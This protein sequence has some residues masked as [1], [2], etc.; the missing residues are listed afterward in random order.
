MASPTAEARFP[1]RHPEHCA[2]GDGEAAWGPAAGCGVT[3]GKLLLAA[4]VGELCP[5]KSR[6][7]AGAM[8]GKKG[9]T[10]NV[11]PFHPNT[12]TTYRKL[13][14]HQQEEQR[15]DEYWEA[16]V[17]LGYAA[18]REPHPEVVTMSY[19][20]MSGQPTSTRP[21][22]CRRRGRRTDPSTGGHHRAQNPN[23]TSPAWS[24]PVR[25]YLP[26]LS[27][28]KTHCQDRQERFES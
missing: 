21:V 17:E 22:L 24:L 27:H 5:E 20:P 1:R 2:G 6:K 19:R 4:K 8:K 12:L 25:D 15:I 9:I 7:E 28:P 16:L 10:R 26:L 13:A 14:K 23:Q 11:I 3:H 18:G